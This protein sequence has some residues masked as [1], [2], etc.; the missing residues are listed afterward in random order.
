MIKVKLP[1]ERAGRGKAAA[2]TQLIRAASQ[3]WDERTVVPLKFI[4]VA[5]N[6]TR[7]RGF[8]EPLSPRHVLWKNRG[9]VKVADIL[10]RRNRQPYT[11]RLLTRHNNYEVDLTACEAESFLWLYR[12]FFLHSVTS[13]ICCSFD[14]ENSE[15]VLFL[16]TGSSCQSF[17]KGFFQWAAV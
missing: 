15:G 1:V 13:C 16:L 4:T 14:V 11:K 10:E 5:T 3:G 2:V 9:P 7:S 8:T 17:L 6:T 12:Y